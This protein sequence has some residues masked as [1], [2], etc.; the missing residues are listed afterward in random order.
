M[1]EPLTY[2]PPPSAGQGITR[3]K[4]RLCCG[5]LLMLSGCELEAGSEPKGKEPKSLPSFP[6]RLPP[7][8]GLDWN[9]WGTQP[10]VLVT[11][12]DCSLTLVS[13]VLTKKV[14]EGFQVRG[15]GE[16]H[17]HA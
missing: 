9:F 10:T 3:G 17:A 13:K 6:V 4:G 15:G 2:L 16:L 14:P 1:S 12:S 7:D 8:L 5:R 11:Q